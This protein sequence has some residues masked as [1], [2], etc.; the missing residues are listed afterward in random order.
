MTTLRLLL[1]ALA[2]LSSLLLFVKYNDRLGG[3]HWSEIGERMS[4]VFIL[5]C[6]AG[7]TLEAFIQG[8][9]FGWRIPVTLAGTSSLLFFLWAGR[10]HRR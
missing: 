9:P 8:A 4:I 1:F 6:L 7:G 3:K 10:T 2:A 5:A